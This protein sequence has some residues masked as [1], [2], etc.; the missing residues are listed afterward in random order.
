MNK[1]ICY[2]S[3]PPLFNFSECLWFLDRRFDECLY[4]VNKTEVIKAIQINGGV[5]L[6]SI[7]ENE[8]DLVVRILQGKPDLIQQ[9]AL[10]NYVTDWFDL[11]TSLRPFYKLLKASKRLT[12][13]C[14][15]FNGL[16]LI[17]IPD[18]FE[19]LCWSIIGQQI[20]LTFAYKLKRRMV[21]AYGQQVIYEGTIYHLLPEPER[22]AQLTV[23]ELRA[24]QFS[25][26]KAEYIITVAKAFADGQL[27]KEKLKALPDLEAKQKALTG[28]KGIGIWT[29]NYALMKSLRE[30]ASIPHG[31]V[32][33]LNAL[34]NHG[35]IKLRT[36]AE[37]IERLFKK[38]KGWESYLVFYLWRSLAKK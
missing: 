9:T 8:T 5:F 27:S 7:S 29:A 35:I 28:L 17:G 2:I 18:L 32:G 26:K 11:N 4:R 24:M 38:F 23:P 16:R 15:E 25:D 6:L 22:L 31:D 34:E 14:D 30:P 21:E 3:K 1:Q 19:A 37:K 12:Y 33:L 20:N 36:E 13:M 10:L